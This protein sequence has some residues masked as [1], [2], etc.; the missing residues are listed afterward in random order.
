MYEEKST[1]T[2]EMKVFWQDLRDLGVR[3]IK[4][5]KAWLNYRR[6]R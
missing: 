3:H 1:G 2:S 4:T 6:K 5:G